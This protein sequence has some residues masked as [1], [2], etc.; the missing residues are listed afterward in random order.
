MSQ[1]RRYSPF[2]IIALGLLVLS[3]A[4]NGWLYRTWLA[5]V[6][7]VHSRDAALEAL[8]AERNAQVQVLEASSTELST[9][10]AVLTEA[11]QSLEDDYQEEAGRNRDFAKQIDDIS[12]T[13][14]VLD[15]LSKTDKE[16]LK[17]YSKVYFLNENYIPS[18]LA[19]IPKDYVLA[20][21]AEQSFHA[22]ALPFLEDMLEAAARD[23]IDLKVTSAYRSFGEQAI[24]KGAYTQSYGSGAN[25]FSADQGYSEHQLGTTVDLSDP[26]TA[27]PYLA[28]KDTTAYAWLLKH[29]YRYGFILSYPDS[30]SY[31]V[32]EPWHWR[33]VGE[34]LADYLHDHN[35]NFYDADQRKIDEYLVSIF[36]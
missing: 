19:T 30:N 16:L 22:K 29:A 18:K 1:T 10:L 3:L 35:L 34:D 26:I 6:D 36:D 32:Y 12:E 14:G 25:T 27:G 24:L 20:G 15:K 33:F 11:Y 21:R 4:G 31:Y 2:L 7:T 17:K 8:T 28:F 9:K 5:E 13:V 23:G